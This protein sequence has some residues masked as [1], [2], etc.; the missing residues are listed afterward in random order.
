MALLQYLKLVDGLPDPR[1]TV[2]KLW[3]HV[4][5]GKWS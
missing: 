2:R 5:F 1:D 3:T 4:I